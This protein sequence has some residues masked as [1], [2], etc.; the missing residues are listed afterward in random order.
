MKTLITG[1]TGFIGRHL[2]QVLLKQDREVRL[3]LR[4]ERDGEEWKRLGAEIVLGDLHDRKSLRKAA[5]NVRIVYHLAGEV[6]A[7]RCTDFFRTN[8]EGTRN[9]FEA[10]LSEQIEKIVHLSSIAASG[11]NPSRE[12]LLTEE[13]P[14]RPITMYGKSKYEGEQ[15]AVR[16]ASAYGLP[17]VSIRPP[18]VYGPGQSEVLDRFFKNIY[19]KKIV[20]V[21]EGDRLRSLCYIDNLIQGLLLAEQKREA[22]GKTYFISDEKVYTFKE[23]LK[24][25]AAEEG[26]EFN[27]KHVGAWVGHLSLAAFKALEKFN[28]SIMPLYTVGTTVIDLGSDISK[29]KRELG[30]NPHIS[31]Q[32]GVGRTFRS[33]SSYLT[34]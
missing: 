8:V 29:A 11:P 31:L 1:S 23:I 3:L 27:E 33:L 32:E 4:R 19:Q 5:Q 7:K 22:A 21:G 28:V 12:T 16:Y 25:I 15:V 20:I 14:C 10:F 17:V 13:M 24:T 9:L 6:Y 18:T 30:Y 26:V 34:S 2:A